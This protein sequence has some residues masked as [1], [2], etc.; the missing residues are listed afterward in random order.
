M[1]YSYSRDEEEEENVKANQAWALGVMLYERTFGMHPYWNR[2]SK[3][4][5]ALIKRYPVV[6][7]DTPR[8]SQELKDLIVDLLNK[9]TS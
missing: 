7:P 5:R 2:D 9:E 8:V 1:Q 4:M 3:I 6:F